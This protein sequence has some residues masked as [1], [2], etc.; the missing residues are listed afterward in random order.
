MALSQVYEDLLGTG[1][2]RT[3]EYGTCLLSLCSSFAALEQHRHP[4]IELT[5]QTEPVVLDLDRV[6]SLGLATSEL[7]FTDD[8][9]GFTGHSAG[10]RHGVGLVMRLIEQI[11]GSAAVPSDLGTE[12][13]LKFPT[14]R[15]LKVPGD[16]RVGSAR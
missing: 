14:S 5:C 11:G 13:T 16:A 6:T 12:W 7:A 8:G 9:V 3:I 10:K 4:L 1:L 2:N 15:D